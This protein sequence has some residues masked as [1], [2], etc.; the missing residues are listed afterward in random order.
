M[1]GIAEGILG[2]F[3][4]CQT[5]SFHQ[6]N[7]RNE[8]DIVCV[9]FYRDPVEV[10]HTITIS[11]LIEGNIK[12]DVPMCTVVS[13]PEASYVHSTDFSGRTCSVS[14][15]IVP[16]MVHAD[17]T[18]KAIRS[19]LIQ[20]SRFTALNVR[21][22]NRVTSKSTFYNGNEKKKLISSFQFVHSVLCSYS[23]QTLKGHCID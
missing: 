9:D 23:G 15:A 20:P 4:S 6:F 14:C 10:L 19:R 12:L 1:L 18:R 5:F 3:H 22:R 7:L 8:F 16:T 2:T 17:H 21:R 11:L 13:K